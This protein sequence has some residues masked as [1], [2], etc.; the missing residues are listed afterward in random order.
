[1]G[2]FDAGFAETIALVTGGASGIGRATC[3]TLAADGAHVV[4]ADLDEASGKTVADGIG[5][6]F[7]RLDVADA[8]AWTETVSGIVE[9]HGGLHLAHLN[10]GV[11]TRAGEPG[12][13]AE[14]FDLA[15]MPDASYRRIMGANVDGVVLGARACLPAIERSGGGA[16]VATASA[17]GVIAFPNDPVYTATKHF[18]VGLVRSL[19]PVIAPRG[20][21][22]HAVLPGA[23]DTNILGEGF[24]DEARARGIPILEPEEIA[25]GVVKAVRDEET[26]GL[27]LCLAGKEPYRYVFN[28]VEGLGV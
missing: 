12:D 10:A 3:R 1:M 5:G 7:V 21:A 6:E 23:V 19:A 8:D 26:G 13:L 14:P 9:R 4:V 11:T 24:A 25:A 27:W 20:V 17:A 2:R 16:I 22:C 18:V 28:P 15:G